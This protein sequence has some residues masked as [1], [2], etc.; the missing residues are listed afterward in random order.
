MKKIRITAAIIIVLIISAL[1]LFINS[2]FGKLLLI[3]YHGY[4]EIGSRIYLDKEYD[5]SITEDILELAAE[6]YDRA[7]GFWGELQSEPVIIFSDNQ[8]NLSKLGL[9]VNSAS[10]DLFVFD[11]AITYIAIYISNCGVDNLAH[12]IS[13]AELY[14]RLYKGKYSTGQL[15][16]MWFN[17]GLAMQVDY[18]ETYDEDAWTDMIA[19]SGGPKALSELETAA[20]FFAGDADTRRDNYITAR[21]EVMTWYEAN[22]HDRL[23]ELIERINQ[24]R[25]FGELYETAD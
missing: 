25:M 11:G 1:I 10:T 9:N 5:P 4:T 18:R 21:H 2:S 16:P 15:V 20:Q 8:Q 12:E 13:H 19:V 14:E 24:G 17:E 3:D 23:L 7:E 22:G 6:S